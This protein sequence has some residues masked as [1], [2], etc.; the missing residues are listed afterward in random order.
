LKRSAA[1]AIGLLVCAPLTARSQPVGRNIDVVLTTAFLAGVTP[2]DT[3][4][5]TD[6]RKHVG[7]RFDAALQFATT[8]V[9][10]GGRL[11]AFNDTDRRDGGGGDIFIVVTRRIGGG[12]RDAIRAQVGAGAE[13][14]RGGTEGNPVSNSVEGTVWS[15]GYEHEFIVLAERLVVSADLIVPPSSDAGIGRKAPVFELGIAYRIRELHPTWPIGRRG[16]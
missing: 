3:I 5:G 11:W 2:V 6:N 1:L 9:G 13:T 7:V 4:R 16:R 10:A 15:I 12:L 8:S 14:I